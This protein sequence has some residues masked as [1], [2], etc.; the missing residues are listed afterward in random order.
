MKGQVWIHNAKIAQGQSAFGETIKVVITDPDDIDNVLFEAG[1]YTIGENGAITHDCL[2]G[3]FD[4]R[5]NTP[6]A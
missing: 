6:E 5:E 4:L 3:D 2:V 1:P